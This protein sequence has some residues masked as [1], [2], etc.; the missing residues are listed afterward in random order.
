[1]AGNNGLMDFEDEEQDES[2]AD[3]LDTQ[4]YED[5][6]TSDED[7]DVDLKALLE[8]GDYTSEDEEEDAEP[9]AEQ[10]NEDESDP[11]EQTEQQTQDFK[12]EEN[13]RNAER[14]R[15]QQQAA[16]EQLRAQLPEAQLV[17]QLEEYYGAPMEVLA[18]RIQM[19]NLQKEAQARGVTPEVIE[20]EKQR[21]LEVQQLQTQLSNFEFQMFESRIQNE[22]Q[23]L[24]TAYPMLT[25]ADLIEAKRYMLV[26]LKHTDIPLEEA[27]LAKFGRKIV[28]GQREAAR[29]E[30]LAQASGRRSNSTLPP[31][32]GKSEAGKPVL[33]DAERAAAKIF[34]ISAEEYLKYK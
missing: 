23:D 28:E 7:D 2:T 34:G 24:K 29:N 31:S 10:V 32:T 12:N 19:A 20:R 13:A 4:S 14:R 21:D 11:D 25:D 9:D 33:T 18:Q 22:M 30:A 3:D 26:D 17:R 5:G 27:V 8:Q 6:D 16:L 15:Q 1:M